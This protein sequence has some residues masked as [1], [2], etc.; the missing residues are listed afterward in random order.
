MSIDT[1]DLT[2][3]LIT[4][5]LSKIH[6]AIN[7]LQQACSILEP[8]ATHELASA[9]K[10]ANDNLVDIHEDF[11]NPNTIIE[12]LMDKLDTTYALCI[13]VRFPYEDIKK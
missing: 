8:H 2:K 12:D 7:G 3:K 11:K 9:I 4:K 10:S 6:N 1:T 5:K 13:N